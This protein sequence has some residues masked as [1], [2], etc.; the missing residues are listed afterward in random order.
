MKKWL[1]K[2]A[3]RYVRDNGYF[4]MK[5]LLRIEDTAVADA[6]GYLTGYPQFGRFDPYDNVTIFTEVG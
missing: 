2:K 6:R 1:L 4:C 3:L 5:S